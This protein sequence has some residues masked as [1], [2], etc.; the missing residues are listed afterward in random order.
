MLPSIYEVL[1]DYEAR[2]VMRTGTSLKHSFPI[3][4]K[5]K[6]SAYYDTFYIL[7]LTDLFGTG[8]RWY[9]WKRRRINTTE[10][11][12]LGESGEWMEI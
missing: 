5:M 1:I 9:I 10:W 4:S 2:Q 3:G 6:F 11:D 12:I 7:T 8:E